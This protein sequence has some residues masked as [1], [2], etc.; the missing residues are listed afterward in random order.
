MTLDELKGRR[1]GLLLSG[2]GAKG[3]YQI[4][5]WK[6]L[7]ELGLDNF[8]AIAG[9]SVGAMNA[10]LVGTGRL[11]K[12]E[13]AW[14]RL[15]S[16]DVF[17][18]SIRRAL[19]LPL[20]IVAALGSEFSPFKITRFA[21]TTA[22]E[23][24]LWRY[25]YPITC[26]AAAAA[27]WGSRPWLHGQLL[28]AAAIVAAVC[29]VAAVLSLAQPL[30]RPTFLRPVL[31]T[32]APLARTLASA[33]SDNDA[34]A[35]QRRGTPVY[36]VL[37]TYA[38]HAGGAHLWGGWAPHYV[39]LDRLEGPA[40]RR[41]LLDGCAVPGFFEA[42]KTADRWVVDG[43]WTDN[44]PAAPL[45]FGDTPPIDVL[46]V[47]CLKQTV[48]LR[49]R[50]NSLWGLLVLPVRDRLAA[51]RKEDLRWWAERRWDTYRCAV[52]AECP[53][54]RSGP[55]TMPLIVTVAPSRRVGTF[56]TGTLWFSRRKAADL[57]DLGERDM[58]AALARLVTG[59]P[60]TAA[61]LSLNPGTDRD[62]RRAALGL[63]PS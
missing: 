57:I 19:L 7:R 35:L 44:V 1:I 38:P 41:T 21:D 33:W 60:S 51:T 32:N 27:V 3:A 62:S 40:L 30:L 9:S 28:V 55:K 2:G 26:A 17:C 42:G 23:H 34:K 4:G 18:L 43:S 54:Q 20:W 24:T 37:S 49:P 58:R 8:T 10:V 13:R 46:F 48:R 47:L 50:H 45:F 52:V 25:A 5:C 59:V 6:A 36:G 14:R 11:D 12:A 56:L 63:A 16:A 15:Q 31:T 53:E 22:H 61:D 29:A 39:R